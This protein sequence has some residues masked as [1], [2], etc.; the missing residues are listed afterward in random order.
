MKYAVLLLLLLLVARETLEIKA[1]NGPRDSNEENKTKGIGRTWLEMRALD[2]PCA[3]CVPLFST[4][5]EISEEEEASFCS[6][7]QSIEAF[8]SLSLSQRLNV[9][10]SMPPSIN[11]LL[12]FFFGSTFLQHLGGTTD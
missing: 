2:T 12:Q 10:Q 7:L 6:I 1:P 9:L 4:A 11:P 3:Q 8:V 5:I